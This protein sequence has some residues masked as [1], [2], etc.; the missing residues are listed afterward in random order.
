MS[1][2]D[3]ILKKGS[4]K[5]ATE[6]AIKSAEA[7]IGAAFPDLLRMVYKKVANG[8]IGPGYQI[9]GVAGG[10]LSDEG[11]TISE[12]YLELSGSDE[13]DPLWV[14][15]Q[16]IVPFCHWGSSVYSCF[17]A[18]K[19]HSP[20]VWFDPNSRNMG[21]PMEQQFKPHRESLE[22]WFQA[23]LDGEDLGPKQ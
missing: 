13:H 14:W 20:V 15:P 2:I 6:D 9:L 19:D 5:T 1:I 21:E 18:T 23:W 10:H 22:S 8:G 7:S 12:L 16:G 17:D 3:A 11:D 4:G